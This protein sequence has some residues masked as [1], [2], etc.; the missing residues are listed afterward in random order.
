MLGFGKVEGIL[1]SDIEEGPRGYLHFRGCRL[2]ESGRLNQID[3][4]E[5]CVQT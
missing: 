4:N 2:G 5:A 1:D 3:R